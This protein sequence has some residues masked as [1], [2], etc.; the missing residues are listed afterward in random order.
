MV[1]LTAT[2]AFACSPC[3]QILDLQQTIALGQPVIIGERLTPLGAKESKRAGGPEVIEVKVYEVLKGNI[4]ES[5]IKVHGWSGMC[6]FGLVSPPH[7]KVVM[8]LE[9][10]KNKARAYDAVNNGCAVK[11]LAIEDGNIKTPEGVMS[12]H[13]FKQRVQ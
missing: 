8:F 11:T 9:P 12:A 3:Q 5:Q 4:T 6:D 13:A 2:E 7:E 1:A 10:S